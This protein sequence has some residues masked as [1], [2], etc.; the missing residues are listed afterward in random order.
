[1]LSSAGVSLIGGSVEEAPLA[2]KNIDRVMDMQKELVDV[3]GKFM[4]KIVR[5][6]KE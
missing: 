3:H 6:N 2:Y 5:M 1:M 4:P